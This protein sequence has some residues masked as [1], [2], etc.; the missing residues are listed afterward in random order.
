MCHTLIRYKVG[1]QIVVISISFMLKHLF[2]I[3]FLLF[4]LTSSAAWA[5]D[6]HSEESDG[7]VVVL[8]DSDH[9]DPLP[10][11]EDDCADH[12]CHAGAHVMGLIPTSIN[13]VTIFSVNSISLANLTFLSAYLAPPYHPPIA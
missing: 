10:W 8:A 7:H 2:T 12:C 1:L 6:D 4:T 13:V 5:L 9:G 3:W 11:S